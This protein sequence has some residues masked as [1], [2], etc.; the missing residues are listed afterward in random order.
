ML[1]IGLVRR[2]P[3]RVIACLERRGMADA[4][5]TIR[6]VAERDRA[7]R[8]ALS[9]VNELKAQRNRA[10]KEIGAVRREGG[11]ASDRI[12]VM[13]EVGAEIAGL[14]CGGFGGGQLA[15]RGAGH[16]PQ[17]PGRLRPPRGRRSQ[18]DRPGVGH[19]SAVSLRAPT[20]LGAWGIARDPRPR[21][22]SEG[23]WV[24]I[25]GAARTGRRAPARADQLDDR[26]ARRRAPLRGGAG[27]VPGHGPGP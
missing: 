6:A 12:A 24:G 16:D 11:D 21:R 10:S 15:G 25:H 8:E 3:G 23:V 1:D 19:P 18:P 2:D 9:R 13:R 27:A 7:R 22:R 17:S 20:P 4:R 5:A 26:T 14:E